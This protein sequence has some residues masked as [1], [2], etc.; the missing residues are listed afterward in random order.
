MLAFYQNVPDDASDEDI[1]NIENVVRENLSAS[2]S[3]TE[4]RDELK[5]QVEITRVTV[6]GKVVR[7]SGFLDAHADAAYLRDDYSPEQD[8]LDN[9]LS[10]QSIEDDE[11]E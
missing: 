5:E 6:D 11:V 8:K 1:D 4:D 10:V 9:P 2:A 3:P 7:V